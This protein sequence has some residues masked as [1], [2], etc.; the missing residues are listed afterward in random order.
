MEKARDLLSE[1]EGHAASLKRDIEVVKQTL[2][3]LES[4]LQRSIA[5]AKAEKE[6]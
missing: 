5:V 1:M 4:K 2:G 6:N 3:M